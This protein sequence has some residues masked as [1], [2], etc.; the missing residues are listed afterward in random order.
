MDG[1]ARVFVKNMDC[2][3][4]RTCNWAWPMDC[5][6]SWLMLLKT[7]KRL[8]GKKL[9]TIRLSLHLWEVRRQNGSKQPDSLSIEA[10]LRLLKAFEVAG[11]SDDV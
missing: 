10:G 9:V 2:N 11:Q 1:L 5:D 8:R 7:L 4:E 3:A 6:L